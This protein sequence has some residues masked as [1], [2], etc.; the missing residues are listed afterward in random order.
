[1]KVSK[2][3]SAANRHAL[4]DAASRLYRERGIEGVGL[5]E[6]ARKAGFTH[7]GFYGRFDSKESLAAEA[8]EASFGLVLDRLRDQLNRHDGD[9]SAHLKNYFSPEHRDTPGTGCPMAALA[10]DAAREQGLLGDAM[11]QGIGA[12]LQ[13]LAMHRPDGTTP[14]PIC[15]EDKARAIHT[16]AVMVGGMVLARACASRAPALSEEILATSVQALTR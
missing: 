9:L 15:A 1:M 5:A 12:Y 10:V 6:I 3:Q 16:L 13:E 7:G 8:C 14:E 2:K 11:A 4:V